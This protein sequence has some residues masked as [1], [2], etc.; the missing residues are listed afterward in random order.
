MK[1]FYSFNRRLRSSVC[2]SLLFFFA[3]PQIS[4]K[5]FIS[6]D[7]P[8][9]DLT[10]GTVFADDATALAAISSIYAQIVSRFSGGSISSFTYLG[11]LSADDL[12]IRSSILTQKEFAEN[13][14]LATN[15]SINSMWS[16][17]Y[18]YIYKSNL[19]LENLSA[20]N[21]ITPSF[22]RRLQGE[23]KFIRAFSFFYL[24][25]IFGDVPLVITTDYRKNAVM[26]RFSSKDVYEQIISD[27]KDA[28]LSLDNDYSSF[29]NERT[30]PTKW[31]ATALLSRV[32]LYLRKWPEA[33]TQSSLLI[34]NTSLF[35]LVPLND[36]FLKNSLE[37]IW[38]LSNIDGN[39]ADANTFLATFLGRPL[40]SVLKNSLIDAFEN[41]DQRMIS[42][43]TK[44]ISGS[45]TY[46]LPYKYKIRGSTPIVEYS[47]V[48]RLA[49]QYLI[50]AEARANQNKIV[51]INSATADLNVIRARASLPG[52]FLQNK[53][54]ALLSIET[55]RRFE[56][57]TEWGHRWL[58]LKRTGRA[59]AVLSSVKGTSWQPTDQLYPLP[60]AEITNNPSMSGAQN[61]GY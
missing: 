9:T 5:K 61:A 10:S 3:N 21:K 12:D 35:S 22:A 20:P 18:G 2:V 16:E 39:T 47:V 54:D 4:C 49:E 44:R 28:E 6:I 34:D 26:P 13:N 32:Y 52:I 58:D 59:N 60:K 41:G 11:G 30:R 55:E 7:P 53:E 51:G 37:S 45:N 29:S 23:A 40:N 15:T 19:I 24:V 57:F 14:L 42:W 1:P 27:L 33:E 36:V 38:Q 46:N 43:T 8:K 17:L 31:V 56:L 50:R 25:N 48:F